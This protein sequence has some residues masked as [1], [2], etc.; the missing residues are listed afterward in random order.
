MS[1]VDLGVDTGLPRAIEEIGDT[2]KWIT[3]LLRDFVETTEIHAEPERAVLLPD[4]EYRSAVRRKGR[5][6]E[7][8]RNVLVNE[9]SESFEFVL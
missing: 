6:D 4:E 5:T 1:E 3:V 2:W 9:F 8:S 7:P